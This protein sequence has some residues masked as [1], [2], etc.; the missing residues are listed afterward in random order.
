MARKLLAAI[1]LLATGCATSFHSINH[2]SLD[3]SRADSS[4]VALQY[5]YNVL[6]ESGNTYYANKAREQGLSLVAVKLRNNTPRDITV[7]DNVDFYVGNNQVQPAGA[8]S[9]AS[10]HQPVGIYSLYLLLMLING[11]KTEVTCDGYGY[12]QEDKSFI[13]I[14]V[15]I[16][17]LVTLIN[18]AMASS[19]N[20]G[21]LKE[22]T[23]N[24]ILAKTIKPGQSASGYLVLRDAGQ[25]PITARVKN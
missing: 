25:S 22:A 7:R 18:V 3:Y 16:G 23:E 21:L 2:E 19:S 24:D 6:D 17:P 4:G 11:Y 13:P 5:K 15:I 8:A 1:A 14:G 12:C 9:M 10:V 20:D